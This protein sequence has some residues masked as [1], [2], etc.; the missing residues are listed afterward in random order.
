VPSA[1]IVVMSMLVNLIFALDIYC[2]ILRLVI[3]ERRINACLS[4]CF[5][6]VLMVVFVTGSIVL[7][8]LVLGY[9]I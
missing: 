1:S 2:G 6:S 4:L 3:R 5:H 9:V 7:I 8:V